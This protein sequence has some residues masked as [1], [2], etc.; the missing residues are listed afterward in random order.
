MVFTL[1]ILCQ[2]TSIVTGSHIHHKDEKNADSA[3]TFKAK[4]RSTYLTIFGNLRNCLT[5]I[6]GSFCN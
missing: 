6:C 5:E 4:L 2:N 1:Y 3:A